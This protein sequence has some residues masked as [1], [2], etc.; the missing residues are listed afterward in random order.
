MPKALRETVF[1]VP[2]DKVY[3]TI[4]DYEC[5]PQFLQAFTAVDILEMDETGG[6]VRYH[7]N[8][9]KKLT[10]TLVMRHKKN[11]SVSWELESGDLFKKN[12][13]SWKL[14]DRGDETTGISYSVEIEVKGFFPGSTM[15]AQKLTDI[16][17]PLMLSSYEEEAKRR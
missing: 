12:Q 8:L 4:T 11:D 14:T 2:I 9:I 10:Y 6:R 15:I 3:E 13:G 7:L 16:Q 5:Y 1:H 17:L